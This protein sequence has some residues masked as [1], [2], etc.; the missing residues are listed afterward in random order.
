MTTM[1]QVQ[2]S[3]FGVGTVTAERITEGGNI[4]YE[5]CFTDCVRTILASAV[6][7]AAGEPIAPPKKPTGEKKRPRKSFSKAVGV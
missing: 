3:I 1:K 7:A 4:V 5:I 2:H 6:S